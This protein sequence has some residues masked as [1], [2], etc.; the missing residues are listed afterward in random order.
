MTC[1][2]HE[3]Q[4]PVARPKGERMFGEGLFEGTGDVPGS[5][6]GVCAKGEGP[7]SFIRM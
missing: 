1:L 2:R 4:L 3:E 5:G 7:Q 6:T